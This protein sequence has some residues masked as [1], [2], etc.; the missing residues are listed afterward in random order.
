YREFVRNH[1]PDDAG[2]RRW[3]AQARAAGADDLILG[4]LVLTRRA[5]QDLPELAR[6]I[7]AQRSTWFDMLQ[8]GTEARAKRAAGDSA[9]SERILTDAL[10]Q[11]RCDGK[12]DAVAPAPPAFR[13]LMLEADLVELH[14]EAHRL[15][16]AQALALRALERARL[17]NEWGQIWT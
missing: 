3:L 11:Y 10:K 4:A 5:Y 14:M 17:G 13:C 8:A 15:Q 16:A 1:P 7:H 12:A 9:G 6:L 2:W